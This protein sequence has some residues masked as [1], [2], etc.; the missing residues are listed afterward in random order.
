MV[1]SSTLCCLLYSNKIILELSFEPISEFF[2][3]NKAKNPKLELQ[4]PQSP[5]YYIVHR[6]K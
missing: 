6:I 5:S 4:F 3:V 1:T 2:F